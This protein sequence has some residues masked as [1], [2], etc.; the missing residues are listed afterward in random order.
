MWVELRDMAIL[1][2]V[3]VSAKQSSQRVAV[4]STRF[5]LKPSPAYHSMSPSTDFGHTQIISAREACEMNYRA[6]SRAV[7]RPFGKADRGK[8]RGIRPGLEE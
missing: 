7:S 6:A 4:L 5:V 3:S 2:K 8:P 1:L